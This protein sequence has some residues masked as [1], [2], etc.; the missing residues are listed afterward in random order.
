MPLGPS[1]L[2][3]LFQAPYDLDAWRN[4][5]HRHLGADHLKARPQPVAVPATES[6]RGI[7]GVLLG[8]MNGGGYRIGLFDFTVPGEQVKRRRVGLRNLLVPWLRADYDAAVVSFHSDDP[9]VPDW[10]VSY[11]CDLKGEET[12]AKRFTFVFGTPSNTYRTPVDRF[13][14]LAESRSRDGAASAD[15]LREAFS[16][17]ALSKEF[18]TEL[19][20]WFEWAVSPEAGVTFP[21][22]PETE[23]DDRENIQVKIIRLIT[24]LLFV[25]FIRQ[26]SLVPDAL[27]EPGKLKTILKDFDPL[28]PA[29][30][31][32]YN[33]ILQNLFFGTLNTP[34][35]DDETGAPLRG[36]AE[37][38]QQQAG[39]LYRYAEMFA[40]S[41]E[42]V[43][44]LFSRIPYMNGGL[45]E[46][47]DKPKGLYPD[48][49]REHGY[50]ML[51]DGF[52]R[53]A[54]K[55]PN[56]NH[57]RR[58]FIP[59]ELFFADEA[60][61]TFTV[62]DAPEA[63]KVSG[64]LRILQRYNFTVEENTPTDVE[65]SL[66]PEL[67]G[68]V[69]ENLLASYNPETRETARH[70]TGSFY[71]PREIVDYMVGQTLG[72]YMAD[73]ESLSPQDAIARLKAVKILDPAC[74]SGAFPMGCLIQITDR[75]EELSRQAGIP[76]DRYRTKLD[77]IENCIYGV[78]IQAIAMMISKLRFFI[79]LICEQNDI[80]A[81]PRDNFGIKVLPNLET[82]FV[83]ANTLISAK[84]RTFDPGLLKD[85]ELL[86]LQTELMDIRKRHFDARKRSVKL[87]LQREDKAK[88]REIK[89]YLVRTRTRPDL[90]QI[91]V[92][93]KEI[94]DQTQRL[95]TLAKPCW[96]DMTEDERRNLG[97][98]DAL[99]GLGTFDDNPAVTSLF[100]I[101]IN[102]APRRAAK[103]RIQFLER[104]IAA[105]RRKDQ[106]EG[107]DAAVDEVTQWRPYDQVAVSPFFDP[108]WM[109]GL[110][111][112]FDIVIGNPPW[113]KLETIKKESRQLEKAGYQVF[114]RRSDL[115]CLFTERG[116]RLLN[117]GGIL[118]FI[119]PNKWLQ[120]EYGRPLREFFLN[121]DLRTFIDFGDN[122]IFEDVTVYPCI[123]VARNA[124]PRSVFD[125]VY[126][127]SGTYQANTFVRDI[128]DGTIKYPV[129]KLSGE[130][131]ILST[132]TASI[133]EKLA[134]NCTPL[135]EF[136]N[137]EAYYG[138][139]PGATAAFI[140]PE[141][142]A[143]ELKREHPSSKKILVPILRGRDMEKWHSPF[144]GWYMIG[145]F[146]ALNLDIDD[147]PAI[148]RF[149]LAYGKKKLEQSGKPGSRKK[150]AN[151]WF[152]TQDQI[153]Y[154]C[155]FKQPKIMYQKFQVSPCFIYDE[156][157]LY[158][159]DS[160]WIMATTKKALV[161]VLNSKMG[162][163]LISQF[164]TQIQNG[165]QLIW[166]YF[167]KIP[168]PKT[169]PRALETL[170]DQIIA[171]K[172]ASPSADTS[173]LES[174]IDTLV[175]RLY[176][177]TEEEI[178][179]VEGK[180]EQDS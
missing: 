135:G 104:A 167:K 118:S 138:I 174:K 101:D 83:A 110:S 180:E 42:R 55:A 58:A 112:G 13:L 139:K 6:E 153:A 162:W 28:S 144:T 98:S 109:F 134:A 43:V 124:P 8:E 76:F 171:A 155:L 173:A 119:M 115:Y 64:L 172:K 111:D 16:V 17:E 39:N 143:N 71:T 179:V 99:P 33:A 67:L 150:T 7:D 68:R 93:E 40:I 147:Y 11:I 5:L 122:K 53:N 86:R 72:A 10:R 126:M 38:T 117:P 79:S 44:E 131:W 103:E 105:E 54:A 87:R 121:Y 47:L 21:N 168:I 129:S 149:L 96:R 12:A 50:E 89:D 61:R 161:G 170:V 148:K 23:S 49:F 34:I 178:A 52:S 85:A 1:E 92:W 141:Q 100:R 18:Y 26:K 151:K 113:V 60:T 136:V 78:D 41:K 30:G 128:G 176:G 77:I 46:C 140:V 45:F 158:C 48:E 137:G 177:L 62:G 29:D 70:S 66:D 107:F 97:H 94:A 3:S 32:Y 130:T 146:P 163:W 22:N 165:Y 91:S 132:V 156:S 27:F 73:A 80:D 59:N 152:E 114:V 56:G 75:I 120:A 51:Y 116:F 81:D 159:N 25:W 37:G 57:K 24:R 95:K 15:A 145:T 31:K 90:D 108:E 175:Y 142:V 65:V 164:C 157:G 166:E 69:F 2:K 84:I 88:C 35:L 125:A 19:F 9:G 160:M 14:K 123:F 106:L 36:F 169:L 133:L 74:G 154:H 4:F 82:K 102:E 63:R 20:D 127:K